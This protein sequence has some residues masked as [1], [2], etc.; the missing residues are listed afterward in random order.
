QTPHASWS[1]GDVG[2]SEANP[3]LREADS[4]NHALP[5]VAERGIGDVDRNRRVQRVDG[6]GIRARAAGVADRVG[7]ARRGDGNRALALEAVVGEGARLVSSHLRSGCAVF[8][9]AEDRGDVGGGE[10]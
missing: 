8:D 1:R 7:V 5:T 10:A 4:L 6:D 3:R 2:G 9:V